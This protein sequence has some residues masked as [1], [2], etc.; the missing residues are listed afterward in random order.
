MPALATAMPIGPRVP[1]TRSIARAI[2][3][4]IGHVGLD[5][6]TV[7]FAGDAREAQRV[8]PE[9]GDRAA[10]R[11]E[12]VSDGGADAL[13]AARDE[14]DAREDGGDALGRADHVDYLDVKVLGGK[15]RGMRSSPR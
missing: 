7:D 3:A 9:D 6:E 11:R 13:S 10:V 14:G 2:A 1:S 12:A 4:G 15:A 8:A 5:R